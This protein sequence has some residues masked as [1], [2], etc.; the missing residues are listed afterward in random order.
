MQCPYMIMWHNKKGTLFGCQMYL[1]PL[2]YLG[3]LRK[4][5]INKHILQTE[6]NSIK[7]PSWWEA[8]QLVIYTSWSSN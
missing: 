5:Q 6:H 7:N 1:V 8:D 2:H 4:L 3:T